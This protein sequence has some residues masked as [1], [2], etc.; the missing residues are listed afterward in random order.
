MLML[1]LMLMLILT[2]C[3]LPLTFSFIKLMDTFINVMIY[4]YGRY[5]LSWLG[6]EI[7]KYAPVDIV[8]PNISAKHNANKS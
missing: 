5:K 8:K 1:M 4:G 6:R 7:L 3:I 2:I